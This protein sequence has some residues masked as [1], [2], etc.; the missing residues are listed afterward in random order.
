MVFNPSR[1]GRTEKEGQTSY[2]GLGDGPSDRSGKRI[3]DCC[4]GIVKHLDDALL[5]FVSAKE[6][7]LLG[8]EVFNHN[9]L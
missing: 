4:A 6:T 2:L 3:H 8:K 7:E 1:E 5:I 9:R